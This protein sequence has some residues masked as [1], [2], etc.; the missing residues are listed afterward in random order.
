MRS[1][2][3]FQINTE[4]GSGQ[5]MDLS[6]RRRKETPDE[7]W[8]ISGICHIFEEESFSASI[9]LEREDAPGRVEVSPM[10]PVSSHNAYQGETP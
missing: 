2:A 10:T 4:P 1:P 8:T 5:G 6:R 7:I 3:C 9:R